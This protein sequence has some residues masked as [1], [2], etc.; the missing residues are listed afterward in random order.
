M[1]IHCIEKQQLCA[2]EILAKMRCIFLNCRDLRVLVLVLDC[3]IEE[4]DR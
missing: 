2:K 3:L 4:R 1:G